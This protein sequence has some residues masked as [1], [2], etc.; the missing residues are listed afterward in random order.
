MS[1][2]LLLAFLRLPSGKAQCFL[3]EVIK[4]SEYSFTFFISFGRFKYIA[5]IFLSLISFEQ[6]EQHAIRDVV[7]P[8]R[9]IPF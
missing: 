9:Q 6:N 7:Y 4:V 3:L 5:F 2:L 1:L 8:N